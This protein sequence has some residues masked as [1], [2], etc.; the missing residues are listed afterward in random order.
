MDSSDN[1]IYKSNYLS[2]TKSKYF[3]KYVDGSLDYELNIFN[4]NINDLK[5]TIN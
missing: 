5:S 1:N 3:K 4:Q 2:L